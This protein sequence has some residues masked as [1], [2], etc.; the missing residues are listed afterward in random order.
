MGRRLFIAPTAI[1]NIVCT[2]SG[3]YRAQF[4]FVPFGLKRVSVTRRTEHGAPAQVDIT[5][6]FVGK[7]HRMNEGDQ[8]VSRKF[9]TW[10]NLFHFRLFLLV[11][12]E[13]CSAHTS[14]KIK[15]H[16]GTRKGCIFH[17]HSKC[18]NDFG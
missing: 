2:I 6:I 13:I 17:V 18:L 11:K 7:L 10:A 9:L 8:S 15:D 12:F 4:R 3:V 16:L 1:C 5:D 14:M